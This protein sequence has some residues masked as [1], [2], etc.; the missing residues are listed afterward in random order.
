MP[1]QMP[2]VTIGNWENWGNL[3]KS[4]V[5]GE[6]RVGRPFTGVPAGAAP[7]L[8]QSFAEFVQQCQDAGVEMVVP[9]TIRAV[10][11]VQSSQDVLLIRLPNKALMLDTEQA[12]KRNPGDYPLPQ[13]Y[14]KFWQWPN[15]TA[16]NVME[17]HADRIGDYTISQC[18]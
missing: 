13:Y 9:D 16:D 6:N 2:R 12:I 15:L 4:W 11:F 3:V 18:G 14:P 17:F 7:P 8:P 5:C 1:L 10:Q